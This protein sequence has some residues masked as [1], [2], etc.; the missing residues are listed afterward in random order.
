[1][2]N[3]DQNQGDPAAEICEDYQRNLSL[4]LLVPFLHFLVSHV[5]RYIFRRLSREEMNENV[6]NGDYDKA[7]EI[8]AKDGP[9][10]ACLRIIAVSEKFEEANTVI[11]IKVLFLSDNVRV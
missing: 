5:V 1:M 3:T 9:Y 6:R 4:Q 7:Y 10:E 11:A 8:E 2:E